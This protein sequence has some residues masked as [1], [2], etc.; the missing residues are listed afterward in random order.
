MLHSPE[1]DQWRW[2]MQALRCLEVLLKR[3]RNEGLPVLRWEI[4]AAGATLTGHVPHHDPARGHFDFA[5]WT[6]ALDAEPRHDES[7]GRIHLTA[8]AGRLDGLTL[9]A[10]VADIDPPE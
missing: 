1:S 4:G 6:V 5:A 9:V 3:Q 2:Q 10:I 7:M 8:T